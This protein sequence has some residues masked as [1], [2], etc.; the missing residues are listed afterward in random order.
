LRA[1]PNP[2]RSAIRVRLA[3]GTGA[4]SVLAIYDVAGRIRRTLR[5]ATGDTTARTL[6]WDGRD[7]SGDAVPA[8]IYFA[9]AGRHTLRLT[10][11]P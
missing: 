8:G 10:R 9:R 5:L 3:A 11:L 1:E 7:D 2:F 6:T 4:T